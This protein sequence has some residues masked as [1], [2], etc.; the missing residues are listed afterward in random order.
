MKS[1]FIDTDV[2][3]RIENLD[4][5]ILQYLE[6]EDENQVLWQVVYDEVVSFLDRGN[7]LRV[8][9]WGDKIES[10][11]LELLVSTSNKEAEAHAAAMNVV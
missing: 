7:I 3:A 4:G 5:K 8:A 11:I 2:I 1:E 9:K 6:I 10:F